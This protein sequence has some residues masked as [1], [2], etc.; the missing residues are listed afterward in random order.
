MSSQFAPDSTHQ[1]LAGC[2]ARLRDARLAAGVSIDDVATRLRMP[3]RVVQSLEAED[4]SRLGAP[5][6]VRGQVRSY[7]RLLGLTTAPMMAALTVEPVEPTKL[8][9]RTHTPKAQGWAEQIGRRLVYIVLTLSLAIPAWVATRQHLNG[10]PATIAALDAPIIATDVHGKPVTPAAP[11]TPRTVVASMAPMGVA[12]PPEP[13][14]SADIVLRAN[15]KSWLEVIAR[16]GSVLEKTMLNDGVEKR[17]PIDQVQR[18]TIG[19][20][21]AVQLQAGGQPL[22]VMEHARANVARFAVSSDGSL[23]AQD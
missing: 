10:T 13:A 8:V 12:A 18:L 23:A 15:G 17:Y 2:G 9:S 1:A 6:F 4:W 21:A 3:A 5:V 20:A 22:N 16:D 14:P 11:A 7:S 19:N